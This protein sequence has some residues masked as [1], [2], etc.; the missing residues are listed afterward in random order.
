M[1]RIKRIAMQLIERHP[2]LFTTDFEAN[3]KAVNN[4]AI[5]R[6]KELRNRVVGYI[7]DYMQDRYAEKETISAEA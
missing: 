2:D 3:K 4:I 1:N 5:F 6:S 7:T